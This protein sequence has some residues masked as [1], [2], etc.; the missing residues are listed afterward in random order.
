MKRAVLYARVSTDVQRDNYSVPT[1]LGECVRFCETKGYT[2]VGDHFV[3][4]TTGQ[5]AN[6]DTQTP[7]PAYVDDY[8]SRELSRPELDAALEYLEA[9]GFDVLIVHALDRLA[10][11]PYIRQTLE[12]EFISRGAK[13]EFVLG[14]YAETAEGEVRKDLDAAFAF[15]EN[16]KRVERRNRGKAERDLLVAG[17]KPYGYNYDREV[18]GGLALNPAGPFLP[19]MGRGRD[20]N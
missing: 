2:L 10:R 15:R 1:Q 17:Q 4:P 20:L 13:I 12:I 18:I 16:A 9:F 7:L 6:G 3:D 8:T 14:D 19:G 11:D 5:T